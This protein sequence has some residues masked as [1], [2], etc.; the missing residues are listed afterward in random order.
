MKDLIERLE[1]AT[2]PDRELGNDILYATGWTVHEIGEGDVRSAIWTEPRGEEYREGDHPDPTA[3]IDAALTLL[4]DPHWDHLVAFKC[5]IGWYAFIKAPDLT[6]WESDLDQRSGAIAI[7]I[8]SLTARAA[9]SQQNH[10]GG[11]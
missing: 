11:K 2:G 5:G 1:K 3:S 9:L 4:P 8:A 7:C 10:T 6:I